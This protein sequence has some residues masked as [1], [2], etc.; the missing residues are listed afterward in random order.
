MIDVVIIR[1]PDF[2][3]DI[4]VFGDED[5][6]V[7]AFDIDLG[8][9]DLSDPDEFAEWAE[10]RAHDLLDTRTGAAAA[11]IASVVRE[12]ARYHGHAIPDWAA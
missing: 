10:S 3:N 5:G 2:S 6:A 4:H 11:L 7:C 12:T 9:A 8:R 1:D